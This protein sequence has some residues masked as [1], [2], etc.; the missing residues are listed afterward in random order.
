M[1]TD[2]LLDFGANAAITTAGTYLATNVVDLGLARDVGAGE[3]LH[4]FLNVTTAFVGGTQITPQII[5]SAAANMG[6]PTVIGALGPILLASLVAGYAASIPLPPVVGLGQRY[7][8]VQYVTTG[9]FSAG[10]INARLVKDVD[11]VKYHA[12]GF[13]VA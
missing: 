3:R 12:S 11:L 8:S 1:I 5:T 4:V 6:S 10:V 13:A 7:L 9:T 2:A